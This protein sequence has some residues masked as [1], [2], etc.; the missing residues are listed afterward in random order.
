[1]FGLYTLLIDGEGEDLFKTIHFVCASQGI[2]L[3]NTKHLG[4]E[5]L[6]GYA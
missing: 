4:K 1:M 2:E 3:R 5:T 6:Y